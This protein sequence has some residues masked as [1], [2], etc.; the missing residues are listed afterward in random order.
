M[1]KR[2]H[3]H[4][5]LLH[6]EPIERDVA[7][8]AERDDQLAQILFDAPSYEWMCREVVD[9]GLN[10]DCIGGLVRPLEVV[11]RVRRID[12]LRHGFGRGG[13]A[14]ATKRCAQAWTAASTRGSSV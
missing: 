14:P 8:V 4:G 6:H 10:R 13:S 12:Y 2:Q 3:A 7:R 9:G 5:V 11:E 1:A